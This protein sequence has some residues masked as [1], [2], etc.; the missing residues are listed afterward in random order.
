MKSEYPVTNTICI[1]PPALRT[2]FANATP[3]H[4]AHFDVQQQNIDVTPP[5]IARRKPL[6]RREYVYLAPAAEPAAHDAV[7]ERTYW[8]STSL[9]SHIAT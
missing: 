4:R 5:L 3:L 6:C 8:A 1:V 7:S 9:S 2:A